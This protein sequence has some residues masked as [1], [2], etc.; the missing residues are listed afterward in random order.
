M[1]KMDDVDSQATQNK[2]TA[3]LYGGA[4]MGSAPNW[5]GNDMWPV[6]PELLNN[7]DITDPKVKFPNSYVVDNTWVSGDKGNLA[8]NLS[9]Q[10]YSLTLD[11]V[12]AVITM[13]LAG[14]R[15]TADNGIIAGVIDTES[16]I[17]ELKK[18]AGSFDQSLC[19]GPTFESIAQ[20]IRAASDIMANGTNGNP[21]RPATPSASAWA[22]TPRL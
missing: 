11:I 21:T 7:N 8:L 20:Q 4:N 19:D 12:N 22:S 17:A 13:K 2:V 1:V 3:E 18:I 16:L 15:T 10:G 5:D 6:V 9:V 14:D